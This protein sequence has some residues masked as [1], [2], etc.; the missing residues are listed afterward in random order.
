MRRPDNPH[1]A[2][3]PCAGQDLCRASVRR[4]NSKARKGGQYRTRTHSADP[5]PLSS[6]GVTLSCRWDY[7][8]LGSSRCERIFRER[9]TSLV[10]K[11][12]LAGA[13]R[14][15]AREYNED[16]FLHNRSAP[17]WMLARA[18]SS[19]VHRSLEPAPCLSIFGPRACDA[20][21]SLARAT[22]F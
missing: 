7:E 13:R 12:D 21:T 22:R 3:R 19:S 16:R 18:K 9:S 4:S 20:P 17:R 15:C 1:T 2:E 14:C 6:G 8:I 5:R 11:Q 10:R